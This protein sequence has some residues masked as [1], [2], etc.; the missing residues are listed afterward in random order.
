[1]PD[2]TASDFPLKEARQLTRDLMKPNPA[3]YWSDFLL[4]IIIGWGA[5]IYAYMNPLLTASG[6]AAFI[7]CVLALYRAV[8]FTHEISHFK[9]GSFK[10]FRFMWNL[11]AGMPMMAPSFMYQG[12][13]NEHHARDIYGTHEDG[14][15]LP[16]ATETRAKI[17]GY[18][19]LIFILPGFFLVRFSVLAPLSW[20]H[21]SV[22]EFVWRRA[23]SL[24]IDLA[25]E[26]PLASRRDDPTW[27]LQELGSFLYIWAAIVLT[28]IGVLSY[29]VFVLWY[30]VVI[31]IFLLNSLR[32][33]AAHKY[34]NPGDQ[35][36]TV[37][38]QFLD[39]VD[40]PGHKFIT[41]LWAPVGLRYH[42]T[43]HLFPNMPY[44]SL[45]KA[46]RRLVAELSDNRLYLKAKRDSLW[47]ALKTIWSEAK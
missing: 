33:L 44:H 17:I 31:G 45:G 10:R 12:V 8:I 35:K 4:T 16:F 14:E 42:A 22:R 18:I 38:E 43:H 34:R 6:C 19:L 29:K 40:V 25:Y 36:M 2:Q 20:V 37:P 27:K 30:A 1:M 28:L 23:S 24:T 41:S 13:H 9:K 21:T 46:H 47:H 3:I 39:S 26:R 5:F 32:T 11:L 15:Y 7:V